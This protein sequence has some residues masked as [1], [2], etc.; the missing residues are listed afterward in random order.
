[1]DHKLVKILS[2]AL[3]EEAIATLRFNFQGADHSRGILNSGPAEQQSLEVALN[4]LRD[5]RGVDRKRIGMAGFSF[6]A[7]VILDG[8]SRY[9]EVKAI[10]L[11]SPPVSAL[12]RSPIQKDR[13]PKLVLV[14]EL[15]RLVSL[16]QLTETIATF[17]PPAEFQIIPSANHGLADH[18]SETATRVAHFFR[19]VLE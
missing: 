6:G 15:D 12:R 5:W 16:S 1:M 7:S 8:L 13:R 2:Q 10:A 14:G 11:I 19:R 9:K 18:E 4:L 17:Q 3:D